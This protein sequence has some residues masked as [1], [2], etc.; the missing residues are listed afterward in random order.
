MFDGSASMEQVR[1]ASKMS[2]NKLVALSQKWTS[3][4]LMEV[5]GDK[6]KKRLFDLNDFGLLQSEE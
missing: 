3:M 2:P 4:G 5:S 6:K 1:I